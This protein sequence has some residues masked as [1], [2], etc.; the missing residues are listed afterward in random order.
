MIK[1][2]R[3]LE[4]SIT[5]LV[6]VT[7]SIVIII[8]GTLLVTSLKV[9]FP[10]IEKG[11]PQFFVTSVSPEN[12]ESGTLFKIKVDAK[13]NSVVVLMKARIMKNGQKIQEIQFYDDGSHGDSRQGDGIYSGFFDSKGQKEGV[14]SIDII[15]NPG[16]SEAIYLDSSKFSIFNNQ[17]IPLIY[18]GD[19]DNKLDV[20]I[21]PSGYTDF[22]KFKS[23][24]LRFIDASG[25]KNGLLSFEPFKSNRENFNFYIVNSTEDLEC[26]KNCQGI[27]SLVCCNDE[28]VSKTAS[29]CPTDKILVFLDTKDFCGT[30]SYYARA[31]NGWNLGEVAV[32][33]FGHAFGGLGDEYD[34][35]KA[36]PT[37][38]IY[39]AVYPNCDSSSQCP[40]WKSYWDGCVQGCGITESFRPTQKDCLMYTYTTQFCEVCQK[41]LSTLLDNYKIST[42]EALAPAP[43]P[44]SSYTIDLSYDKGNLRDKL[45]YVTPEKS[46]D[47]KALSRT[48]YVAKI[49]SFDNKSLYAF[50]FEMPRLL[51]PAPPRYPNE[52]SYSPIVQDT[53]DHTL[54]APY[55]ENAKSIEV[56]DLQNQKVLSI[57]VAYLAKTCG[58]NICEEHETSID[59]LKDCRADIRDNLC[60]YAKDGVCDP[61]CINLDSDCKKIDTKLIFMIIGSLVLLIIFLIVGR[62]SKK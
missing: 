62:S 20:A 50:K 31:C 25:S 51:F 8:L 30:A 36:Y 42:L 47:R 45:V 37:Y 41:T 9:E 57:D 12:A 40:K 24:A 7:L 28:K 61:D 46:P 39:K 59:C 4:F 54:M 26:N 3:G 19:S 6:V 17:C 48:D 44:D 22:S 34:Y 27:P 13:N 10:E 2:K 32:H 43:L 1:D 11:M 21:L 16:E 23:D 35:Q 18:N 55:F 15:I 56:Y 52:T 53:F 58:N 38:R 5:T 14:Y 60:T 29:Q 49:V 33:E